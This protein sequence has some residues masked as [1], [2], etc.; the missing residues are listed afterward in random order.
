[1]SPSRTSGDELERIRSVRPM[2]RTEKFEDR[3][4]LTGIG[5]SSVGRKLMVPPLS[6]TVDAIRRA[7]DDA[8]LAM[9]DI[10]GLSTYPATPAE[11]GYAEGRHDRRR[12]DPRPPAD[13][14]QRR[15]RDT[16]RGTV[17]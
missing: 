3:V 10:D 14:A 9:D 15:A 17:R 8:G 6:L 11:G 1:M 12:V 16:R 4:A 7:V 5:M 13:L 2:A